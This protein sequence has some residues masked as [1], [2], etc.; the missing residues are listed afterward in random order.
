VNLLSTLKRTLIRIGLVCALFCVSPSGFTGDTRRFDPPLSARTKYNFNSDWKL[1]IGDPKGVEAPAFDDSGWKN[2]TLPHAWNEDSAFK[3]SIHDLP[4]GVAWYRKRFRL[5]AG[6]TDKKVFLEFEGIRQG[7]E[8]FL[9]GKFIGRHENGVMAFGFDITNQLNPA[10][11]ENVLAARIDNSWTYHEQATNSPFQWNDRNFYANYGGINKN[12]YMHVTDKL[13]QTLPLYSSLGTTGVYVHADDFD[14]AGRRA[15]ITAETQVKNERASP[16]ACDFEVA[17]VDPD[18]RTIKTIDSGSQTIAA[19]ETK[20]LVASARVDYLNFWSWGY[21]YLYD[22]Y[23]ILK[24]NGQTVDVVRTRTG[25]RK[26]EFAHGIVKLND[27]P[28]QLKG[29]AQRTTNEWPSIGLSVP[30]WMSDFSN[31]MIVEG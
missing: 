4:T 22:V 29:Y 14:I 30:P 9:N 3:V 24:V 18:R 27:N 23:T 12:V 2:V 21:G 16:E 11:Q 25:F 8:F 26:T 6:T 20:T 7:G 31:R 15:T 17:I 19:G 1:L 5:P 28:I 10:P 13:Y